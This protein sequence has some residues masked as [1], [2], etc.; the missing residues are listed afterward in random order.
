MKS[1]LEAIYQQGLS[2]YINFLKAAAS[3]SRLFS[4]STTPFLHYRFVENIYCRAF[5]AKNLGR[6]DISY[7]AIINGYGIGLKTFTLEKNRKTEKIAEFNRQSEEINRLEG[8]PLARKLAYLRNERIRFANNAYDIKAAVYHCIGRRK[9]RLVLFNTPYEKI[10]IDNITDINTRQTSITFDDGKSHYSYNFSKST[11]YKTFQ[12]DANA[13]EV[14]VDILADPY[15]ILTELLQQDKGS[16]ED[17]AAEYVILP[18]YASKKGLKEKVVP[19]RSGLNQWNAKGRSRDYGEV[20]IPVP[21]QVHQIAPHFFPPRDMTFKL[22]TP[23]GEVLKAKLCQENLKA[24][25]TNPNKA[26]A[27]WLLRGIFATKEGE[28]MTYEKLLAAGTD[29]VKIEKLNDDTFSIDFAEID[30]YE[31]FIARNKK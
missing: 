29:S 6:K 14:A 11:L 23:T 5:G 15:S 31:N 2:E 18:L 27:D 17:K 25:M 7:D 19:H 30:A 12:M 13:T 22:Q 28:L 1:N 4:N 3:L 20:Y 21:S 10:D 16:Y 26:L 9:N 24:L 8:R